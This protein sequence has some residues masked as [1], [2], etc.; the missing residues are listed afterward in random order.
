MRRPSNLRRPAKATWSTSM[1]RPMPI[2]SVATRKST[3]PD[4]KSSTW[5]LRVRGRERSH[6]HRR[7][8]AMAADQFGDGVDR[9]GREGDDGAAARQ[10]GQLL[11][12]RRRSACDRRSRNWISASGQ[13]RRIS[14]ATV[15]APISIV[16]E[17]AARVQQAVGEDVAA[18][19]VGA[20]LDFV[21]REE[22][23]LAVERHRLDRADEIVRIGAGRSSLRR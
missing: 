10:A 23:D 19:G 14:G 22:L 21:D 13:R 17:R 3:S 20:E 16:S 9:V 15:A 11:R 1:L 18:L 8:A 5:A 12:R 2:A 4:W 7:A 6:H